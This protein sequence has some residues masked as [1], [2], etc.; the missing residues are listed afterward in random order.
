MYFAVQ[1]RSTEKKV[2]FIQIH[3]MGILSNNVQASLSFLVPDT[4]SLMVQL[5]EVYLKGAYNPLLLL[6]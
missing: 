2:N 6:I 5:S 1:V 4:V 3:Q